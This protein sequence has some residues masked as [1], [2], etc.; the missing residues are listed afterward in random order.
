M[1]IKTAL[2]DRLVWTIAYGLYKRLA[3]G[4]DY[5]LWTMFQIIPQLNCLEQ[6]TALY[7]IF[8]GLFL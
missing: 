6:V 1:Y 8:D 2:Y 4:M 7:Y 5:C 3:S